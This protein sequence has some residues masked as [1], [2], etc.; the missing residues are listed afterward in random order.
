MHYN[1]ILL[2]HD[3]LHQSVYY[4]SQIQLNHTLG[5]LVNNGVVLL[6]LYL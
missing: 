4:L 2:L 6:V 1:S 5:S 3:H